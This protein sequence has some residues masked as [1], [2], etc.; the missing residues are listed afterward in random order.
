MP[1]LQVQ[2]V[3]RSGRAGRTQH[4]KCFRLYSQATFESSFPR[5]VLRAISQGTQQES[6]VVL[7]PEAATGPDVASGSEASEASGLDGQ[8]SQ[9]RVSFETA[10][11][12]SDSDSLSRSARKDLKYSPP[13]RH[14]K[15]SSS[16]IRY[17]AYVRSLGKATPDE[18]AFMQS[19]GIYE[20]QRA[21]AN[22]TPVD[23]HHRGGG[24]LSLPLVRER[25]RSRLNGKL[26]FRESET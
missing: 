13:L 11:P 9:T 16:S 5:R 8:T 7:D 18:T 20:T 2:A 21:A 6:E 25:A 4:G 17:G 23:L 10:I 12:G 3:Q 24:G 22:T 26:N 14:F 15:M 19:H 1:L